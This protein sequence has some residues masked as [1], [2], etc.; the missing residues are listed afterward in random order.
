MYTHTIKFKKHFITG[1]LTDLSVDCYINT[2]WDCIDYYTK[3]F[4]SYTEENPGFEC[5]TNNKYYVTDLVV[6][7]MERNYNGIEF[8]H[9]FG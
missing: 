6:E 2:T 7:E 3:V 8:N 1:L 4:S 5:I 9:I